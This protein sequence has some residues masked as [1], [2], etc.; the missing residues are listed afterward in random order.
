MELKEIE[1]LLTDAKFV[2]LTDDE[3]STHH[4]HRLDDITSA[5]A[6]AHLKLCQICS[7]RLDILRMEKEAL[8]HPAVSATDV[9]LVRKLLQQIPSPHATR[10][11]AAAV[12]LFW[13]VR[14][15]SARRL[16]VQFQT[17]EPLLHVWP[18]E[19]EG[20]SCVLAEDEKGFVFTVDSTREAHNGALVRF[21]LVDQGKQK[22]CA[23]G[24]LVL[25]PDPFADGHYV[26]SARLGIEELLPADYEPRL[27]WN[28]EVPAL[29]ELRGAVLAAE[30]DTDRQ[31]WRDWA[32]RAEQA[33]Q[34]TPD[35][36]EA[37]LTAAK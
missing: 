18:K 33:G 19:K 32:Q 9:A 27:Q 3:L 7:Q 10:R 30:E 8:A 29:E 37:I 16:A 36:A 28:V 34:L 11:A 15:A 13:A 23:S 31:A 25:H 2:H 22:E 17:T 6:D 24:L 4:D 1:Q 21:A 20:I 26:A 5:R 14:L 12:T 35:L